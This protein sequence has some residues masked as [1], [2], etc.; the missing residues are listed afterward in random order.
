MF[1]SR[2]SLVLISLARCAALAQLNLGHSLPDPLSPFLPGPTGSTCPAPAPFGPLKPDFCLAQPVPPALPLQPLIRSTLILCGGPEE[3]LTH[4]TAARCLHLYNAWLSHGAQPPH[5][6]PLEQL[7]PQHA[8]K[9]ATAHGHPQGIGTHA[10]PLK[11]HVHSDGQHQSHA[12]HIHSHGAHGV[13]HHDHSQGHA[14]AAEPTPK[15]GMGRMGPLVGDRVGEAAEGDPKQA[16]AYQLREAQTALVR[17]QRGE[18]AH[19]G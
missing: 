7:Q 1:C 4:P 19:E 6:Q 2:L 10:Q 13:V 12:Y 9:Q 11:V 15:I 5:A 18:G 8:Q 14:P 3:L 17:G 16:L